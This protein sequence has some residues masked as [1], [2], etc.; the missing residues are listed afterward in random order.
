[1]KRILQINTNLEFKG[2]THHAFRNA[3]ISA[4]DK[5]QNSIKDS[6]AEIEI[7]NFR[8]YSWKHNL[9]DIH[10]KRNINN[11]CFYSHPFSQKQNAIFWRNC[12]IS[13]KISIKINKEL[14]TNYYASIQVFLVP[15]NETFF[16]LIEFNSYEYLIKLGFFAG[17]GTYYSAN[18]IKET[19]SLPS[20]SELPLEMTIEVIENNILFHIKNTKKE[21]QIL[22][23]NIKNNSIKYNIGFA[24]I[25]D[26][27]RYCEWIFSNYVNLFYTQISSI[28]FD[29][30]SYIQ[31]NYDFYNLDFFL[32]FNKIYLKTA[33]NLSKLLN[34]IKKEINNGKYI[35]IEIN[36]NLHIKT[37]D[38]N[39][40]DFHQN[41]IYGYDDI[42]KILYIIYVNNGNYIFSTM[43]Y[44]CFV[45]HRNEKV[46]RIV[47]IMK[48]MPR[49]EGVNFDTNHVCQL[50]KEF[51]M[52]KN[53]SFYDSR[54][55]KRTSF[56]IKALQTLTDKHGLI[57]LLEDIRI[58]YILLEHSILDS[59]RIL[60]LL[61]TKHI[62]KK[63]YNQLNNI[64]E[65]EISISK[66]LKNMVMKHQFGGRIS[67]ENL[68]NI[69]RTLTELKT[70]FAIKIIKSLSGQKT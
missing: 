54:L 32:D 22:F 53:I 11:I 31:K 18:G 44:D 56:G 47:T 55:S 6:I 63:D 35:E 21:K 64:V 28:K 17:E 15:E 9:Q 3:I 27:N 24:V 36:D 42:K 29:Y 34:V 48:Y 40:K 69:L 1:M 39:G 41:L 37:N 20:F 67:M 68:Q 25:L 65:Q 4:P 50:Y 59:K 52:G 19:H 23:K 16:R 30:L 7:E 14:Y 5:V 60:Y 58:S 45:S 38:H 66:I 43:E 46:N 62:N 61:Y 8:N 2:Y 12:N 10:F 57:D 13:D 51:L 49:K 26:K 70:A 33:Q